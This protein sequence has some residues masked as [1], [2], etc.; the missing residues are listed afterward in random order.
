MSICSQCSI[1]SAGRNPM[2]VDWRHVDQTTSGE[3]TEETP[4]VCRVVTSGVHEVR[5][6]NPL[7]DVDVQ[8]WKAARDWCAASMFADKPTAAPPDGWLS[9]RGAALHG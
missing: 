3:M 7:F 9:K 6:G 2:Y 4:G 1:Q 5:L 8:I